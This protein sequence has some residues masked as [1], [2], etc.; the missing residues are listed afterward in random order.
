[1]FEGETTIKFS[2]EAAKLMMSQNMTSLFKM[3]LTVTSL[4]LSSYSG[5]EVTF[6]SVEFLQAQEEKEKEDA[7]KREAN[8]AELKAR[9]EAAPEQ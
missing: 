1:M 5:L 3:P 8:R 7:V 6:A 4:E 2:Q 9:E